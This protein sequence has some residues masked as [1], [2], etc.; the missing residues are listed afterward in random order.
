MFVKKV[1]NYHSSQTPSRGK[2]QS[3]LPGFV[4]VRSRIY[5]YTGG[6]AVAI[7][8]TTTVAKVDGVVN[9]GTTALLW[10]SAVPPILLFLHDVPEHL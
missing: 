8:G 4:G 9:L 6:V 2:L 7:V 10:A 5:I 3:E 1:R